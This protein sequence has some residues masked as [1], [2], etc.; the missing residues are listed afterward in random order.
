MSKNKNCHKLMRYDHSC[1]FGKF[2][3]TSAYA[4]TVSAVSKY[5]ENR[6]KKLQTSIYKMNDWTK[7]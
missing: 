7:Y 3:A 5:H 6:I 1:I 4:A 2:T